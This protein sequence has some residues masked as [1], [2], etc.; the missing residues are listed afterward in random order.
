MFRV[1]SLLG[2]VINGA[3]RVYGQAYRRTW[4]F[5]PTGIAPS[6]RVRVWSRACKIGTDDGA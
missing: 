1:R 3:P 5:S 2:G 6:R 4:I